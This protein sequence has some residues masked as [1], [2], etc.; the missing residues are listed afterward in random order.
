M[1]INDDDIYNRTV[2]N[3]VLTMYDN[4]LESS[5]QSY[6]QLNNNIRTV[7][8]GMREILSHQRTM[9][10]SYSRPRNYNNDRIN[11]RNPL[12]E[13]LLREMSNYNNNYNNNNNNIRPLNTSY[14]SYTRNE[15][16]NNNNNRSFTRPTRIT[17][18]TRPTAQETGTNTRLSNLDANSNDL[19][20]AFFPNTFTD[21]E[22]NNLTSVIV[23]PSTEEIERISEIIPF[24]LAHSSNDRMCPI[25]QRDFIESDV[26]IRLRGCGHCFLQQPINSWFARSVLCP[27]C[28]YDVRNYTSINDIS[29][30]DIFNNHIS[31]N[32]QVMDEDMMEDDV[33]EYDE[34]G[35]GNEE[36]VGDEDGVGD[37][38]DEQSSAT[39]SES[40]AMTELI[41]VISSQLSQTINNQLSS[42]PDL[43]LNNLDN[44]GLNLEYSFESPVGGFTVSSASTSSIGEMLRIFNQP[45][46]RQQ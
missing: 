19:L 11:S 17:R 13:S 36:G 45:P 1:E 10:N 23:R 42:I 33:E 43:S 6:V 44:N 25:T 28:R 24:S 41:N 30:N 37:E 31:N 16:N 12:P 5:V 29:N 40:P 39:T 14:R 34:E 20:R 46:S 32:E 4:M 21:G 18:H 27:V 3:R 15:T 35:V 22:F 9:N 8:T 38:E 7:E 2:I 26:I